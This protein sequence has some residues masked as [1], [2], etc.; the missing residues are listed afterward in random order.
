[1]RRALED[2]NYGQYDAA[3]TALGNYYTEIGKYKEA[4][5][6]FKDVA[7]AYKG[8]QAH[9]MS[10]GK[11]HRLIGEMHMYMENFSEALSHVETYLRKI[12]FFS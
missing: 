8:K 9:L 3:V 10:F 6:L 4:L 7:I 5:N 2:K 1:M 11:A 12:I